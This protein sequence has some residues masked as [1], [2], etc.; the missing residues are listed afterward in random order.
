MA[1]NIFKE[2]NERTKKNEIHHTSDTTDEQLIQL[3][4]SMTSVCFMCRPPCSKC[5]LCGEP[6]YCPPAAAHK[7]LVARGYERAIICEGAGHKT[8]YRKPDLIPTD[9]A[10]MVW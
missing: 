8:V 1:K 9:F 3:T 5:D 7:E 10:A 6:L 4:K 2:F